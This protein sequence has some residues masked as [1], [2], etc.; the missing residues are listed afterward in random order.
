MERFFDSRS[1]CCWWP[2]VFVFSLTE[3]VFC[4][5][6]W[7]SLWLKHRKISGGRGSTCTTWSPTKN[8]CVSSEDR[9]GI[10]RDTL[11]RTGSPHPPPPSQLWKPLLS[12]CEINTTDNFSLALVWLV[13]GLTNF[14]QQIDPMSSPNMIFIGLACGMTLAES[15][16]LLGLIKPGDQISDAWGTAVATDH[17]WD[18][19]IRAH[20]GGMSQT[21]TKAS[22]TCTK[23]KDALLS[24]D[25]RYTR[26]FFWISPALPM[27]S[28]RQLDEMTLILIRPIVQFSGCTCHMR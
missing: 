7:H 15:H 24:A 18:G 17:L 27:L 25:G 23:A 19:T 2:A 13:V 9:T 3:G 16:S 8:L 10:S 1:V 28:A 11:Q 12:C 5:H 21:H 26:L 22:Q 20:F 4:C 6:G 14:L